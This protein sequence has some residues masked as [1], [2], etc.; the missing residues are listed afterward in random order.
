MSKCG[1]LRFWK[2]LDGEQKG[3][4]GLRVSVCSF[5]IERG[6][7]WREQSRFLKGK[8]FDVALLQEV[9]IGCQRT[10]GVNV[11]EELGAGGGF[12]EGVWGVEFEE[13]A[14]PHRSSRLAGGGFHGNCV[15]SRWPI[16]ASGSIV[17][18]QF[19]SWEGHRNQPRH[20]GRITV[21]ADVHLGLTRVVR[22]Y[23][24][25]TEN[26]C[27]RIERLHQ[28]LE[29]V[30]HAKRAPVPCLIGGD[31]NTLMHGWPRMLPFIYPSR[32]WWLRF[33]TFGQSEAQWLEG[34]LRNPTVANSLAADYSLN[35]EALEWLAS[36]FRDYFD[37]GEA[38]ATLWGP[39]NLFC[40][41]LDWLLIP[42]CGDFPNFLGFL[43]QTFHLNL[44][45]PQTPL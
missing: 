19:Y 27:G 8:Q 15:L 28:L 25:H 32:S 33:S 42:R 2:A 17:H 38:G 30:E 5:N 26:F 11:F 37:K 10:G 4:D 16:L 20:G 1:E 24:S 34:V 45:L 36:N 18:T 13:L 41:K 7:N 35:L 3:W 40:A 29:V 21:W 6:Y 31:L 23:S 44:T 9:D 12:A 22:F 14:S 39:L 43:F